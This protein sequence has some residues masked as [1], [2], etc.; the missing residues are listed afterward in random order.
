M[1]EN[2]LVI[3]TICGICEYNNTHYVKMGIYTINGN[4]YIYCT[5]CKIFTTQRITK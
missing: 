3:K 2:L 4:I 5:K 1:V